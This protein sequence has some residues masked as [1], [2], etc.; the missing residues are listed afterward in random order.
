MTNKAIIETNEQFVAQLREWASGDMADLRG[1]SMTGKATVTRKR[2]KATVA[3][4]K[5]LAWLFY[6]NT[7]SVGAHA[8]LTTRA[9]INAGWASR[10]G[11]T[12][13]FPSGASYEVYAINEDGEHAL[14]VFLME[15][16]MKGSRP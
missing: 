1:Y 4:A 16:R 5:R 11:E 10:T 6:G 3:Q 14:Q 2:A 9:I 12:G 7:F 8:D 13:K 15:K